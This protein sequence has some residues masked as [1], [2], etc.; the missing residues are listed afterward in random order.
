MRSEVARGASFAPYRSFAIASDPALVSPASYGATAHTPEVAT[1]IRDV[2]TRVLKARG[3][4][5]EAP[6]SADLL[7][8]VEL[9]VRDRQEL[10]FATPA[11][12]P[13][14]PGHFAFIP[15]EIREGAFV[16]GAFDRK[17]RVLVWEGA[18]RARVEEGPV[19]RAAV[20]RTVEFVLATFPLAGKP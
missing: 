2:L 19:D 14:Y 12:G 5:S 15:A 13:E 11:G 7:L 17:T 16:I 6:A 4:A 10:V 18:A 1:E 8:E 3:Y 20:D 9:G